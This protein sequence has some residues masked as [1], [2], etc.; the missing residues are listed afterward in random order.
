MFEL[1]FSSGLILKL[2]GYLKSSKMPT[3]ALAPCF[4]WTACLALCW[5]G[6]VL[7]QAAICSPSALG[8]DTED[9]EKP[10]FRAERFKS[11]DEAVT[12][13]EEMLVTDAYA[14]HAVIVYAASAHDDLPFRAR[15]TLHFIGSGRAGYIPGRV[16]S[17]EVVL[18]PVRLQK[19]T[20]PVELR[21]VADGYERSARRAILHVGELAIW[22]DIALAP[23]TASSVAAALAGSRRRKP[24]VDLELTLRATA[25]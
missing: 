7:A 2:F 1:Q 16:S 8:D 19:G 11:F 23:L 4:I 18:Q 25:S 14:L 21:I 15:A 9:T 24:R 3:R 12:R 10:T 17:E 22:D 20:Q 6:L 5:A 13:D